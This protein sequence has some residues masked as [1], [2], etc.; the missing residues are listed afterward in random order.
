MLCEWGMAEAPGMT[1][2]AWDLGAT[3]MAGHANLS[4]Q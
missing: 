2:M 1:W 4:L 3:E